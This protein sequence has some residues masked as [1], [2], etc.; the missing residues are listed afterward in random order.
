MSPNSQFYRSLEDKSNVTLSSQSP[1]S[2][3]SFF[4]N[5]QLSKTRTEKKPEQP[6]KSE[7]LEDIQE[8]ETGEQEPIND[9]SITIN[10]GWANILLG[11]V[12]YGCINDQKII[13]NIRDF[14]QKKL[15]VLK[16]SNN[17]IH[18]FEIF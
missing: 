3:Y 2:S 1:T 16:V 5:L 15:S 13:E 12:V 8:K 7:V 10:V 6:N 14:L 17:N 9:I 4:K 11:R 18:F